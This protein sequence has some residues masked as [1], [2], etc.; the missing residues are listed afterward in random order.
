MCYTSTFDD[1][2]R[3]LYEHPAT[4]MA[5]PAAD[6]LLVA[7]R[8]WWFNA[9]TAT[10]ESAP[11]GT[12]SATATLTVPRNSPESLASPGPITVPDAAEPPR[13]AANAAERQVGGSWKAPL[14]VSWLASPIPSCASSPKQAAVGQRVLSSSL[15]S[16]CHHLLHEP[17]A[18]ICRINDTIFFVL[19]L[20]K[21]PAL[22]GHATQ[23]TPR[24]VLPG[25]A[26]PGL[27]AEPPGSIDLGV[28]NYPPSMTGSSASDN[29]LGNLGEDP[30]TS[31]AN[32]MADELLA[33]FSILVPRESVDPLSSCSAATYAPQ[34]FNFD[35]R[36][37]DLGGPVQLPATGGPAPPG[38]RSVICPP[39]S[40]S[41]LSSSN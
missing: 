14:A 23:L 17:S 25:L 12:H 30:A 15:P 2:L 6:K 34:A 28:G 32:P 31:M 35:K 38:T 11:P 21:E 37:Q 16:H 10:G 3:S 20:E 19:G 18:V 29:A 13:G 5:N 40:S 1:A 36:L 33:A 22:A 4:F 24:R 41:P 27:T 26:I 7:I 39:S 9:A 8:L